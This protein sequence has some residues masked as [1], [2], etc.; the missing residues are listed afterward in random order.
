MQEDSMK[1][2]DAQILLQ[3]LMQQPRESEWLEFKQNNV[4]PQEIGEYISAL[5]NSAALLNKPFGYIVWGIEDQTHELVGTTFYPYST[6]IKDQELKN[7]LATQLNPSTHVNIV[8]VDD[9]AHL[10]IFK[11]QAA[12]TSPVQ[13]KGQEYIRIGSYKKKLKDHMDKE[14][15][16]WEFFSNTSFEEGVAK[17]DAT[18]D[19]VLALINYPGFFKL[20]GQPLP[21]NRSAI[22]EKLASEQ[23]IIEKG[24]G[25][26]YDITNIGAVLF[27]YDLRKFGRLARKAPRVIIYQGEN[28]TQTQKEQGGC[29]GYAVG[30]KRLIDYIND[31]FPQNEFIKD[32]FRHEARMYPEIA[33]RELVANALI[34]Q[35]FSLS[36]TGPMIEIFT[37]R[38][39]ISNPGIPLISH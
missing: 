15:Q 6:K 29:K 31:Q 19:E 33:I 16:L 36:G 13:F 37:D 8:E 2:N 11:I 9:P 5:A 1:Q 24:D 18:S 20:T 4:N 17:T 27:A 14:R 23:I 28:R 22:L 32:A 34:H 39:E 35:D 30:F 12:E 25:I 10:V 21:D 7:W 26:Y 3:R 38:V